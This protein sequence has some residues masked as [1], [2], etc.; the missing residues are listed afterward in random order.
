MKN[1]VLRFVLSLIILMLVSACGGNAAQPTPTFTPAV[2]PASPTTKP[3]DPPPTATPVP[4]TETP[5]PKPP[6]PERI[7]FTTEDGKELE[8]MY[9]AAVIQPSPIVV[10]VH[11]VGGN[12]HD[13]DAI[14]P[15]I[16]G[17]DPFVA[18]PDMPP[19][20]DSSWFPAYPA[21]LNTAVFSFSLRDCEPFPQGCE[22]AGPGKWMKDIKAALKTAA[23]LPGVDPNRVITMGASIGADGALDGCYIY[24]KDGMG[25]CI[26]SF[27]LSPGN[28]MNM[29]YTQTVA[30]MDQEFP[31]AKVWCFD[32][33]DEHECAKA[34]TANHTAFASTGGHGMFMITPESEP[35]TLEKFIE[36]MRAI[37]TP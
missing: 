10:L 18:P 2:P 20:F 28:Y 13:W 26:G 4:P 36:F 6:A 30:N 27:P 19:Y 3:T 16:Q 5:I 8:G 12:L 33:K 25:T 29:D 17:G 23:A 21:E 24:N 22:W 14:A 37:L 11:W 15:W 32:A 1:I 9:Y 7:T 34:T 35:K 31:F